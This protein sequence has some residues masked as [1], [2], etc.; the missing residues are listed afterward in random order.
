MDQTL[1]Y[2][3]GIALV[4]TALTISAIGLRSEGFPSPLL[5]RVGL[6]AFVALV[7]GTMI[8]AVLNA[9]QEQKKRNAKRAAEAASAAPS[10]PKVS[11]PGGTLQ[12]AASRTQ[13]AF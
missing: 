5:M 6:L 7:A 13:L 8:F 1:F 11:G 2:V 3:L 12:L 10:L 4:L 9:S